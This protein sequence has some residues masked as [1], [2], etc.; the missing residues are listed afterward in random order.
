M[1]MTQQNAVSLAYAPAV[2]PISTSSRLR[3]FVLLLLW[4]AT[5]SLSHGYDGIRHD[6]RL[7]TLQALAHA[8]PEPLSHDVFLSFG[9][10]DQYSVFSPLYAAVIRLVGIEH[11]A[12]ILTLIS[13]LALLVGALLL[14]RRVASPTPALL[15]LSVLVAIPGM[16]G[17]FSVFRCLESFVTPRMG[18]EAL[19]LC[20]LAA[21]LGARKRLALTLVALATLLHPVMAAAGLVALAYL[22]IVIPKPRLAAVLC[23]IALIGLVVFSIA[24][25]V[26][27]FV[28]FDTEW[29]RLV[30]L[31]SPNLF[32]AHWTADDWGCAIIPM[33]T[34][35]LGAGMLAPGGART[36]CH[37][38]LMAGLGGLMLTLLA[39]DL[40]Q[41][42]TFTQ[43]QPWRWMWLTTT[44]A[45]L[46]LPSIALAGWQNGTARRATVLLLTVAWI[47]SPDLLAPTIAVA[48]VVCMAIARRFPADV[49]RLVFYGTCG[50]LILAIVARVAWNSVLLNS[51]YMDPSLPAWMR[52]VMS[53]T[54]D[55]TVNV[56][57]A[58][59]TVWLASRPKWRPGLIALAISGTM[60]C[61]ALAPETW[62]RWTHEQFPPTVIAGFAQ[63]RALIPP[64]AQVLWPESPVEASVLLER[65]DYL[66]LA[67]TT[68]LVFSRKAAMEQWRR[69]TTLGSVVAPDTFFQFSGT[70]LSIGASRDQLERACKTSELQFLVTGARLSWPALAEVPRT[71]WHASNGLRLYRCPDQAG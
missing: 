36:L 53:V 59:L 29:L 44:L 54:Q 63:W 35:I 9:S 41:L 2:S 15:G 61:V 52:E 43:L 40:L 24:W 1:H 69:A 8:R 7:Y 30:R 33:A 47:L 37:V 27:P 39:C 16:Y 19:V 5:W 20:S 49:A 62:R 58:S 56:A 22:Y 17:S 45:A 34:L 71:L 11:A 38:G 21:A 65:P 25:P 13:Q 3:L 26:P 51:Y 60:A 12:A 48:A 14:A 32:L 4:I 55:G 6:G 28:R 68:G 23:A 50:L 18:S 57:I 10:Q 31:R 66:S 42:V 64:D 67:Q 46:L 70:G